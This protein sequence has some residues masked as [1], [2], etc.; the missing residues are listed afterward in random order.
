MGTF[1]MGSALSIYT[2]TYPL[3]PFYSTP[4]VSHLMSPTGPL[5][6]GPWSLFAL[7]SSFL[8]DGYVLSKTLGEL[9]KSKPESMLSPTLSYP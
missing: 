4:G 8:L 2:G 3:S 1:W 6:F 5:D 7:V 9:K